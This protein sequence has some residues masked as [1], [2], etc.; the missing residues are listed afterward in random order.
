M[1]L[2]KALRPVSPDAKQFIMINQT[3]NYYQCRPEP[4]L[5]TFWLTV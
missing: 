3:R 4:S 2:A 5:I 1:N